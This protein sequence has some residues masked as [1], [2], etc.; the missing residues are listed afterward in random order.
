M[1]ISER[2]WSPR[3]IARLAAALGAEA[4]IE[5]RRMVAVDTKRD[6]LSRQ[7][8]RFVVQDAVR[9]TTRNR[10]LEAWKAIVLDSLAIGFVGSQDSAGARDELMSHTSLAERPN[11]P[12]INSRHRTD[13]RPRRLAQRTMIGTPQRTRRAMPMQHR[14]SCPPIAAIAERDHLDGKAFLAAL[15]L[16]G[17]IGG[18]IE[19]RERGRRNETRVSQSRRSGPVQRRSCR[20]QAARLRRRHDGQRASASPARVRPG[21]QEFAFEGGGR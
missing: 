18:R 15:I 8:A 11:A 16:G 19:E 13:A 21:L 9:R 17:E 7:L 12:V 2:A 14:T 20:R 5:A 1:R 3:R 4:R 6:T 10:S